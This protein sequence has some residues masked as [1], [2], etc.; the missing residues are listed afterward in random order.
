MRRGQLLVV[1]LREED[2]A[3]C[4]SLISAMT[5][6]HLSTLFQLDHIDRSFHKAKPNLMTFTLQQLCVHSIE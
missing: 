5:H 2:G 4:V 1:E 6:I 3:D